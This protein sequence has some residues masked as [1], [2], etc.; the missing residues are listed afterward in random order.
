MVRWTWKPCGTAVS[1]LPM[2]RSVSTA[3]PVLPRR[4]SSHSAGGLHA[5]PAAV[6]PIGVVGLVA[7]ARLLLGVEPRAP[8][9][10]HLLDFAVGDDALADQP[11]GVDVE[12]G[13]MRADRLVHQRLGERRLVALVVAEAAVAEHVDHD[14]HLEL[15][16]ELGRDLGGVHHRLGIVAVGVEDRRLDHLGDVGRIRRRAR[17]AR[18]GGEA[19]LVVDDEMHRAA[20][21]MAAQAGQAEAFRDHA[22]AGERRVAGNQQRHHHGAV[23]AGRAVLVL[24]GARLAEHHRIDDLQMRRIGGQ[25]QMH[26]GCRRTRGPTRRRGDTSRRPS[27]RRRRAT[28]SRP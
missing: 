11:L 19:D 13:R 18:I 9:G 2:S 3:T 4:G 5:G 10:L 24:L 17:E 28:T 15:L 26:A 22:L 21:A 6:E 1:F 14:R 16:P 25:R 20:G 12:R 7:L 8:V 27:L 23:F